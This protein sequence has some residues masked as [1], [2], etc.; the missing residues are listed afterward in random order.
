MNWL[1]RFRAF[2]GLAGSS[3]GRHQD[4]PEFDYTR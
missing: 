4:R 1:L 2:A 3:G